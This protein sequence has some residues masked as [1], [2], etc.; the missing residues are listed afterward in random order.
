MIEYTKKNWKT[1]PK[2][3]FEQRNL[4]EFNPVLAPFGHQTTGSRSFVECYTV[5]GCGH[6]VLN[7]MM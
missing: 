1:Y 4:E 5:F 2:T 3:A 6:S 7:I